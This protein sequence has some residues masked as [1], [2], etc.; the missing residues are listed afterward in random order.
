MAYERTVLLLASSWRPGGRCVAGKISNGGAN[1]GPW[2]RPIN[3]GNQHAISENDLHYDDGS[4]AQVLDIVS[5]TLTTAAPEGHQVEN[6]VI[7]PGEYWEKI[8]QANWTQVQAA[9]DTI[10]GTLWPINDSSY[11][12]LN[13][14]VS[15]HL[16][17]QQTRS[18]VLIEPNNLV[19]KVA[20][21]SSYTGGSKRRIRGDFRYNGT[22]YNFVVTDPWISERYLAKEDGNYPIANSR[23]CVSLSEPLGDSTTKLIASVITP[24]RAQ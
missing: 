7:D 22:N 11:H 18:L 4:S 10:P 23:I 2:L 6:Q 3:I 21:E 9:T 1:F 14:K 15:I 19:L 24:E 13:D 16:A 20:P 12:G 17:A 8:G 5:M